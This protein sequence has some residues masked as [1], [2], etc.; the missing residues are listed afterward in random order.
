MQG[1]ISDR[2]EALLMQKHTSFLMS[3]NDQG[4]ISNRIETVDEGHTG[5]EQERTGDGQ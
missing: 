4:M 5:Y 3:R 2:N 1:M